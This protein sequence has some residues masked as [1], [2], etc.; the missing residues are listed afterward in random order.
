VWAISQPPTAAR[1]AVANAYALGRPLEVA[2]VERV[3]EALDALGAQEAAQRA[4][5][6]HVAVIERHPNGDLRDFLLTS[7]GLYVTP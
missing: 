3:V 5:A 4:V 1:D 2:E 7:L 6:E